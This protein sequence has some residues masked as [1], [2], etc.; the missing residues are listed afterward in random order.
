MPETTRQCDV[1]VVGG[2]PAGSTAAL[3]AA[4]RGLSVLLLEKG[5]HPRFH[6]GES[7]LP[8]TLRLVRELGLEDRLSLIPQV[9][10]YGATFV[11]GD[12]DK[13]SDFWFPPGPRGEEPFAFNIERAPFD[14]MLLD[15]AADAGATVLEDTAVRSIDTLATD[16]VVLTTSAGVVR[17]RMLLDA[18]G[19][20]TMVGRHRNSRQRLPD[21][22]RVAYFQHFRG[23]ERREGRLGGSPII[24]LSDEGW[25]WMIPLDA[26]RTSIGVVMNAEIA[27][28]VQVPANRMLQWAIERCPYLR[29]AM[30]GSEGP[31]DN[32]VTADFSYVCRPFAGPG[33]FLIGDAATFV[34]PIFST[35]VCMAMMSAV[36]AADG[37]A[38]ILAGASAGPVH[39]EYEAFV[40]GSSGSFFRLVRAYYRHGFRELFLNGTGP[41]DVHTAVL[42]ALAGHVFP[43][44]AFATRWR[45]QLFHVLLGI[46]ERWPLVPSRKRFSLMAAQPQAIRGG[47]H[48]ASRVPAAAHT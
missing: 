45:L 37:A 13:T 9:P 48:L 40:G 47:V 24:V 15:A 41:L 17:A 35:G 16:D 22:E 28:S 27:R 12:D 10:K 2:G 31:E 18:S 44:P 42:S 23:V 30:A 33:Y 8:R 36:K 1:V 19:Q 46:H 3:R 43:R 4:R 20:G 5:R 38:V 7:M 11:M 32:H 34:D 29:R 21:L 39:R 26:Q 25:F 6:I 14:R